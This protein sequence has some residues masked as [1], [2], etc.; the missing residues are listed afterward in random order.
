MQKIIIA[1][2]KSFKNLA[3]TQTWFEQFSQLVKERSLDLS[4]LE[5]VIAPAYPLLPL[6]KELV[7]KY[8][9]NLKIGLQ[10]ISP[11][12]EGAYTGEINA[13]QTLDFQVSHAMVGHSER[14]LNFGESDDLV[15][16]KAEQATQAGIKAVI[17][18]DEAY[19]N[20]QWQAIKSIDKTQIIVAYEPINAISTMPGAKFA[21]PSK[22][23]PVID[24]IKQLSPDMPTI[25]GGSVNETNINDYLAF[26]DGVL[27]GGAS[28]NAQQFADL[29]GA[30]K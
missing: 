26:C 25:Y 12:T 7:A 30:I 18:V 14:R 20:S 23:K 10:D 4:L 3:E 6:V 27:V 19:I 15:A 22:I 29:L 24:Q 17:C 13:K 28:L 16:K 5:I 2:W 9:L 11:F 8:Q 21:D 1:N